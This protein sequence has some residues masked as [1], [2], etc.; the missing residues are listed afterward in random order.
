MKNIVREPTDAART[1]QMFTPC[2]RP[3]G[4]A[5]SFKPT[6]QAE[7]TILSVRAR[8]RL[9]LAVTHKNNYVRQRQ[10]DR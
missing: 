9:T 6:S 7:S 3:G 8:F 5:R 1:E 2:P 4:R 10:R